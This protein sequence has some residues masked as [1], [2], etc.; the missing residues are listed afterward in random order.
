MNT[1]Q[2]MAKGLSRQIKAKVELYNGS[3]LA[4]SFYSSTIIKSIV[5]DRQGDESKFFGYGISQKATFTVIDLNKEVNA[6]N[7]DSFKVYFDGGSGYVSAYP[8]FAALEAER[9]DSARTYTITG[10]DAIFE[11][12]NHKMEEIMLSSYSLGELAAAIADLIGANGIN[13]NDIYEF[14]EWYENGGNFEGIETLREVLDDIAEFTQTVYFIDYNGNLNFKRMDEGVVCDEIEKADYF[15]LGESDEFILTAIAH[16][17]ELGDEVFASPYGED[18]EGETQYLRENAFMELRED[19]GDV[20]D[21]AA[22]IACGWVRQNFDLMWRGNYLLEAADKIR[23]NDTIIG[24]IVNDKIEYNG[25]FKQRTLYDYENTSN[26]NPAN[27]S[28]LGEALKQTYARVDKANKEVAIVAGDVKQYDSRISSIEM[29]TNSITQSV[30]DIQKT[31]DEK[32]Q[33]INKDTAELTKQVSTMITSEQA[34]ILITQ[35]LNDGTKKVETSTGYKFDD[36]GLTISKSGNEVSTTITE[37]GMKVY[38][39]GSEMLVADNQGVQAKD[40]HAISYLIV[41]ANSRFEDYGS[42]TGCFWIGEV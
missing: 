37:D 30:A 33:D 6:S 31:T 24:Y 39:S 21:A 2:T 8:S 11:A 13:T 3:A 36:T 34:Q 17:T 10:Y 42:R 12:D 29:N 16:T 26:A 4:D 40:L 27:P 38:K 28:T 23:I 19:I 35:S 22:G 15:T 1:S 9:Y 41:G 18:V 7:F 25:G 32:I 14:E 20:L 5:I